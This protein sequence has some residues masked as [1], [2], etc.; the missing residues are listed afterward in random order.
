[1]NIKQLN[2]PEAPRKQKGY[3][4][5]LDGWRAISILGVMFTHDSLHTI[6]IFNSRWLFDYG[7]RGVDV[8]FAISGI[9]I[10][11]RLI[12]EENTFGR[13][14][15]RG[16]YIRRAF[17]ILPAALAY[18]IVIAI[19]SLMGYIVVFRGEWLGAMFFCRNYT[20][21]LRLGRIDQNLAWFTG[22]FWSLSV[23]EH[24]Y[25]IFPG[26]MV[27]TPKRFRVPVLI[28][29][30]LLIMTN[31]AIQLQ[32]RPWNLI[33]AHTDI[34]LDALIVPA[35]LAVLMKSHKLP[36]FNRVLK[37]WPLF[38][39]V[40][41]IVIGMDPGSFWQ[42]TALVLL[43]PVIVMGS[44]LHSNN[45]F[46]KF[47]EL[48][49]LRFIGRISYGLYL[50]QMLFF[51]GHRYP[52]KPLGSLERWPFNMIMTFSCALISYYLLEKPMMRLGH[53]IAPPA[54]PGREDLSTG[55]PLSGAGS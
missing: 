24:F 45:I 12:E 34:R 50:W 5:T 49:P 14:S 39:I 42:S 54:T 41:L 29:F 17:R 10:C 43:L 8:F 6:G 32:S 26:L 19:L 4:P 2:A 18:L 48:K 7:D 20:S 22:H 15:L 16:F 31:R 44:V 9:L 35:L 23:E 3:M 11:S 30:A 36:S 47:L 21:L 52:L 46:G 53:R 51:T 27:L 13:I 37:I 40:A 25:L 1:M 38:V 33:G 28:S 55:E